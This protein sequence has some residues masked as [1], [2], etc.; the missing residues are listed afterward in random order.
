[1]SKNKS[2]EMLS[3]MIAS[4]MTEEQIKEYLDKATKASIKKLILTTVCLLLQ[5]AGLTWL[6]FIDWRIAIAVS[7]IIGSNNR[8]QKLVDEK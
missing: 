7:V 6:F 2:M 8:S 4:G 3:R 1:M 5:I